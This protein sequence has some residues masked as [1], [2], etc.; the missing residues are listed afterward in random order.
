L[1]PSSK[2]RNIYGRTDEESLAR[3]ELRMTWNLKRKLL[4]RA[5]RQHRSLNAQTNFELDR[6]LEDEPVRQESQSEKMAA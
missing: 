5:S 3:V 1:F 2:S 4:H 6:I